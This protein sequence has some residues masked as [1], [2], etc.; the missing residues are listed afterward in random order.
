MLLA[1]AVVSN[2]LF[3]SNSHMNQ[4]LP[5]IIHIVPGMLS[6]P[7]NPRPRQDQEHVCR[8]RDLAH[9]WPRPVHQRPKTTTKTS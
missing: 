1:N 7:G 3:H 6:R 5:Q 4:M 9:Q 2:V 8:E